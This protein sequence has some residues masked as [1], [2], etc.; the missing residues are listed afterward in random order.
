MRVLRTCLACMTRKQ[1]RVTEVKMR[2]YLESVEALQLDLVL[3]TENERGFTMSTL[4]VALGLDG[5]G[6][7]QPEELTGRSV[8]ELQV[9]LGVVAGGYVL[10]GSAGHKDSCLALGVARFGSLGT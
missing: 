4:N 5:S 7:G 6:G 9:C 10:S 3:V 1:Q 2:F 8:Q